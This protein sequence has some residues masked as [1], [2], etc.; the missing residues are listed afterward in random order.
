MQVVLVADDRPDASLQGLPPR[1]YKLFVWDG[2][3]WSVSDPMPQDP[4]RNGLSGQ[5]STYDPVDRVLMTFGGAAPNS[6]ED[7]LTI[8]AA[9]ED[10]PLGGAAG[11]LPDPP[12]APPPP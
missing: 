8:V 7:H 5:G 12:N 1:T 3:A 11:R 2:S 6:C 9:A 10:L 4:N